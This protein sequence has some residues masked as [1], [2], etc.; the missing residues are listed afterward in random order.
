MDIGLV[1]RSFRLQGGGERQITYL[2]DGLQAQG[3]RVQLFCEEP[4]SVPPREGLMYQPVP[5]FPLPHAMRALGFALS[6][7][8][9]LRG[10]GLPLVQSFDR[11][12][13]QHIYRAGEGVHREWLA[14]KR[15]ALTAVARGWSYLSLFDRVMVAL[16]RRVFRETP[17]IIANSQRGQEEIRRHYG[18]SDTRMTTI[19]NGVDLERFHPGIRSRW[20]DAQRAAWGVVPDEI[21]LL[22]VGSGFQ[23]KGLPCLIE[24]LALLCGRGIANLRLVI[25]GKGPVAPYQRLARQRS[26]T[27]WLRFEGQRP[28]VER[29]YAAADLFVL[30]TLY[31]PF[32]NACLE[33][34]ACGLPVLTS[35]ANGAAELLQ[36]G[37]NG[38]VLKSPLTAAAL[39]DALQHLLPWERRRAMGEAASRTACEH[40]L[41]RALMQILQVYEAVVSQPLGARL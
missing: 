28:D 2:I 13:G 14:R 1:K 17:F 32:A 23:R 18:V 4:P 29:C 3:Y 40:P 30:P 26:L 20:R 33:A 36:D 34:M 6:V 19:Y 22:W 11:T 24:A 12:L 7:R 35:D 31:D 27:D 9:A 41:S 15:R 39:A 10:V 5:H 16:E 21:V 8:S 38:H 25:V 37:V